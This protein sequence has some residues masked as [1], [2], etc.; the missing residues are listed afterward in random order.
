MVSDGGKNS[1]CFQ[2]H[3]TENWEFECEEDHLTVVELSETYIFTD[4]S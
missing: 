1:D 2:D 4:P 3:Q